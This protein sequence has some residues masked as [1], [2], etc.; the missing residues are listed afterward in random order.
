[1]YCSILEQNPGALDDLG[2]F[3]YRLVKMDEDLQVVGVIDSLESRGMAMVDGNAEWLPYREEFS[4]AVAADGRLWYARSGEYRIH[5]L[6]PSL[7][8]VAIIERDAERVPVTSEN[9]RRYID[10]SRNDRQRETREKIDIGGWKPPIADILMDD[11]GYL[12]VCLADED[13]AHTQYDVFTPDGEYYRRVTLPP[14]DDISLLRNG[15]A[16]FIRTFEVEPPEVCRGRIFAA[17][18]R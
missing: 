9:R 4:W 18:S 5:A 10:E 1:M 13:D 12:L 3:E 7:E 16:Y 11:N 14:A 8:E 15:F 2:L 6:S 17:G